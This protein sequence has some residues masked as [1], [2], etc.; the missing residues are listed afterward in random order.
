VEVAGQSLAV[1]NSDPR[2]TVIYPLGHHVGVQFLEEC[3][4]VLPEA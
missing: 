1:V 3:L 2:H 4:Y